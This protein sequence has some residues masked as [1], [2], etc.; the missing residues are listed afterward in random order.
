MYVSK[1]K[2]TNVRQFGQRT[3]SFQ[4]GFNL[5]VG[6]NGK[7]KTTLL[8]ALLAVLGRSRPRHRLALTDADIKL[9]TSELHVSADISDT[10]GL[11]RG[12]S[13]YLRRLGRTSTRGGARCA[14][15]VFWYGSNEA[16]C[17]SFV[18]R[19]VT[20][21]SSDAHTDTVAGERW[22]FD[23]SSHPSSQ[24]RERP[25]FGRSVDVKEFVFQILSK[26]ARGFGDFQWSFEPYSCSIRAPSISEKEGDVPLSLRRKLEMAIMRHLQETDNPLRWLDRASVL[27]NAGGF[28]DHER[29]R[30]PVIPKFRALLQRLELDERSVQLFDHCTA[31]V[32]LTPRIK[33]KKGSSDTLLL[34]QLSDGE[35]RL[36][37]MFV[38]I[39]RQLSLQSPGAHAFNT[40]SAVVLIDEIDVH[41]HPKWQRMIVPALEDMFPACQ[42]IATTHS[43]FVI[44]SLSRGGLI[45]LRGKVSDSPDSHDQSIEDIVEDIQ[46]IDMPQRSKRDEKM[47]QASEAY[48]T[49]LMR[50]KAAP[51]DELAT[52]ERVYRLASEPFTSQPALNALLKLEAIA[53]RTL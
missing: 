50:G 25:H 48:F 11:P 12:T 39:A 4:P 19:R 29:D 44:Q 17:S 9:H 47:S 34:S 7:G 24:G 51:V 26:F 16:T 27:I 13:T 31:E 15:L 22:L 46:G 18:S 33:I 43:P 30:K 49:L 14:P 8:R 6:E 1:L 20:R 41:L 40:T 32:R 10:E 21:Y 3:I 35:Q 42:F 28:L 45:R 38:D 36:F 37:S 5:L 52:A 2:L 23:Q 53:A